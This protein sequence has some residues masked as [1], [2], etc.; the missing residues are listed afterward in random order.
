MEEDPSSVD[1]LRQNRRVLVLGLAGAAIT[2]AGALGHIDRVVLSIERIVNGDLTERLPQGGNAGD[3][4]RLVEV[5]NHMLDEIERLM[6]EVKGARL[7]PS[8]RSEFQPIATIGADK[9]PSV[10][11]CSLRPRRSVIGPDSSPP[12]PLPANPMAELRWA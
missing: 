6:N 9:L 4:N 5:V 7:R 3:V 11:S 8:K 2:G 1:P 12:R 10:N